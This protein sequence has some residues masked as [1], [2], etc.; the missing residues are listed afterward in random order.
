MSDLKALAK[1]VQNIP[2]L[3]EQLDDYEYEHNREDNYFIFEDGSIAISE[4]SLE[5]YMCYKEQEWFWSDFHSNMKEEWVFD[6]IDKASNWKTDLADFA[7]DIFCKHLGEELYTAVIEG[8][9]DGGVVE[10]YGNTS[11]YVESSLHWI[12]SIDFYISSYFADCYSKE[13]K[14]FVLGEFGENEED[15][16]YAIAQELGMAEPEDVVDAIVQGMET[17]GEGQKDPSAA[18][19]LSKLIALLEGEAE[20]V[21]QAFNLADAIDNNTINKAIKSHKRV[22][23]VMDKINKAKRVVESIDSNAWD[24]EYLNDPSL[25]LDDISERIEE[26]ISAQGDKPYSFC[27]ALLNDQE[28][29]R[30]Y[31]FIKDELVNHN[32]CKGLEV[33]EDDFEHSFHAVTNERF[34]KI[35]EL[36]GWYIALK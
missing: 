7:S 16:A 33:G 4:S 31:I 24:G 2:Q 10:A 1:A 9:L 29:W 36:N 12:K 15:A 5:I 13:E 19:H 8:S 17:L 22:Q 21:T 6:L 34:K 27:K 26:E 32:I 35:F 14:V 11:V 28:K 30:H 25:L 23:D 20:S 18:S 3:S